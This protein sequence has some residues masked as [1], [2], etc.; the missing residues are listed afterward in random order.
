MTDTKAPDLP[1]LSDERVS[2]ADEGGQAKG[3][4]E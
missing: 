1:Q 4:G 3:A 2:G